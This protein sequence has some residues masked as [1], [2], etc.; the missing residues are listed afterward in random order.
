MED[1]KTGLVV[2]KWKDKRDVAMMSSRHTLEMTEIT[3]TAKDGTILSQGQK[4]NAVLYYNKSK[5]GIDVSDQMASYYTPIRKT[6]RWYHKVAFE[7]LLGI[8]VT[9]CLLLYNTVKRITWKKATEK[10][11]TKP[12]DFLTMRAFRESLILALINRTPTQLFTLPNRVLRSTPPTPSTPPITLQDK[13]KI[14][15][16]GTERRHKGNRQ[17]RGD[18]VAPAGGPC[19]IKMETAI[20]AREK[21]AA[22]QKTR[23]Y[24]TGCVR[25]VHATLTW[26][27]PQCILYLHQDIRF[28][29]DQ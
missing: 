18:C 14:T 2:F 13:H 16:V 10:A 22:R 23:Y 19:S 6:I 26:V 28:S 21:V 7:L 29:T 20:T 11:A 5:Q 17:V 24:C 9:N 25:D 3:K 12:R 4:P 1:E 15:T 8:S 27:C